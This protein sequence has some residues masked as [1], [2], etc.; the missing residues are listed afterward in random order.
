MS[1]NNFAIS[2]EAYEGLNNTQHVLGHGLEMNEMEGIW[3]AWETDPEAVSAALPPALQFAAP[4]IMAYVVKCDTEFAGAYNEACMIVPCAFEGRPGGYQMSLLLE[5]KGAPMAFCMGREMAGMPKKFCDAVNVSKDGD[6]VQANIVKD[7]ITVLDASV[8]LGQYNTPAGEQMFGGNEPGNVSR[9]DIFLL[10]YNT[11]QADDGHMYFD[12]GRV[13]VT[14]GATA[15]E[16][17]TP[18]TAELALKPCENAPWVSFP[19]KQVLGAGYGKFAM[20][21][22]TTEKIGEFDAEANMPWLLRARYDDGLLK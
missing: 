7:G 21:E 3:V 16:H 22:F 17:W 6:V 19:V 4:I 5:G 18:G 9:A 1:M 2:K 8:K 10:K 15:Y 14:S 12:N 20:K 13:L 11:E